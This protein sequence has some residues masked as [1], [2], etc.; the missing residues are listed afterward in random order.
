MNDSDETIGS[1]DEELSTKTIRQENSCR[2]KKTK[3]S[4][5]SL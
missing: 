3:K 2:K 4:S 1:D 5:S